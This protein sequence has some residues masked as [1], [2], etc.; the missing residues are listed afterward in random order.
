MICGG[1]TGGHVYPALTIAEQL[2]SE[3]QSHAS[4]LLARGDLL[5]VGSEGGIEEELVSRANIPFAA[6]PA[7]GLRGK[8]PQEVARNLWTMGRGLMAAWHLISRFNPHVLFATGGYATVPVALAARRRG[9]PILVYLPDIE[10]GLAV[11]LLSHLARHVA[12]TADASHSFFPAGKAVTTGYPV[13]KRLLT[14]DKATSRRVL[15]LKEEWP[16]LLVFGGSQGARSIN[17]A[18]VGG[19]PALLQA[20]QVLHI[21]GRRDAAEAQAQR[22]ALPA[23]L[24]ERYHLYEYLHE[25]MADALAAADLAVARAGASVMGELPACGLPGVLVPYPYAGAHQKLNARYLADRGA[26]IILN[27]S[28]LSERLIPTVLELL[29]GDE[30]LAQMRAAARSLARPEAA[31]HIV[32][33]LWQLARPSTEEVSQ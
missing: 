15:D 29:G 11:R 14:A 25:E 26:A 27:D 6:I 28:D 19:L 16:V 23:M 18:L 2:L 8:G 22:Q 17:R 5:Y 21:S 24:R 1:G 30:R 13:R 31:S 32:D 12:V 33:L 20:C 3:G 7:A 4:H 10:P 9:V